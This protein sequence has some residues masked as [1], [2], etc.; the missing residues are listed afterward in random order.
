MEQSEQPDT[1][2]SGEARRFLSRL[3][4]ACGVGGV[5]LVRKD[6][7]DSDG[8]DLAPGDG[9]RWPKCQCGSARCP[10][11]APSPAPPHEGLRAK[12]AEANR[13]SRKGGL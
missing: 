5:L 1:A 13:R 4:G 10:D 8:A 2:Q 7:P 3:S 12:V 6:A 9:L 11:Y